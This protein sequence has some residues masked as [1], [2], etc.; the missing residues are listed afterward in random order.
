MLVTLASLISISLSTSI[1]LP[2]NITE[3]GL[4][5]DQTVDWERIGEPETV[6]LKTPNGKTVYAY[7]HKNDLNQSEI[8]YSI[9]WLDS[10]YPEASLL[11]NPTVQYNCHSYAWYDTSPLNRYWIDTPS[12]YYLDNNLVQLSTGEIG[13]I[14]VYFNDYGYAIHSGII[15]Y[16]IRDYTGDI[17][18]DNYTKTIKDLENIVINSKWGYHG[19]Y[20]HIGNDCPYKTAK[21]IK[22]YKFLGHNHAYNFNYEYIDNKYHTSFCSCGV[23]IT[24]GHVVASG[25]F[26][27]DQRYA[28]CLLCK[29][30]ASMGFTILQPESNSL[31]INNQYFFN[32]TTMKN[33]VLNL[34]YDDYK[35]YMENYV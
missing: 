21:S 8:D 28:T 31:N 4:I 12:P 5:G 23:S 6:T 26:Q 13:D 24:Q 33:G 9:N 32:K 18:T 15:A 25:S 10:L 29:G 30:I 3:Y 22:Y 2:Y 1:P 19:L 27:N 20:T 11:R 17:L 14:V 7:K 34:S 35:Y 16:R